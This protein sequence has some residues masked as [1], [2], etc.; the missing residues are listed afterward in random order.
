MVG[1]A[2]LCVVAAA[3]GGADRRR[4]TERVLDAGKSTNS[5]L[6]SNISSCGS[7]W[8]VQGG[9]LRAM[10]LTHAAAAPLFR[11]GWSLV[12]WRHQHP[13]L[14]RGGWGRVPSWIGMAFLGSWPPCWCP[15][16]GVTAARARKERRLSD[17]KLT[18]LVPWGWLGTATPSPSAP[19]RLQ[20]PPRTLRPLGL[21]PFD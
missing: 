7:E 4:S 18:S 6:N 13:Q 8:A 15:A 14:R 10:L 1:W 21:K 3:V 16:K 9:H 12:W 20:T 19:E 2:G 5:G 17:G 11:C